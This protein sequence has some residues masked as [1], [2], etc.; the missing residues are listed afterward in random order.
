MSRAGAACQRDLIGHEVVWAPGLSAGPCALIS[1][2]EGMISLISNKFKNNEI[3]LS[4]LAGKPIFSRNLLSHNQ[5]GIWC[6]NGRGVFSLNNIHSNHVA[7]MWCV[8]PS[9]MRLRLKRIK[10]GCKSGCKSGYWR[11]RKQLGGHFWRMQTFEGPS[12]ADRSAS[13]RRGEGAVQAQFCPPPL[14]N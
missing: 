7:G 12:K 8:P 4:V 6:N 10:G 11:F 14:L 1:Q 2:C 9:R 13:R 3:A 5:Y